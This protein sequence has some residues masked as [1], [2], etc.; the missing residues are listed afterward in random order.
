MKPFC[1]ELFPGSVFVYV[2]R[3]VEDGSHPEQEVGRH[4]RPRKRGVDLP[5]VVSCRKYNI[6]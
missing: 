6:I 5:S 2:V 4:L 1:F 3:G